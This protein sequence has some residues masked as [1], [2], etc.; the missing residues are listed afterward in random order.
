VLDPRR[1]EDAF[2]AVL[3]VAAA[4]IVV[5]VIVLIVRAVS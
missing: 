2:R 4:A 1:E 3:Y 5:I